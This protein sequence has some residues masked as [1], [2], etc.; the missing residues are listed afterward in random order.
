M[1]DKRSPPHFHQQKGVVLIALLTLIVL[2]FSALSLK[3]LNRAELKR[4]KLDKSH[5]VLAEAKQALIAY[6]SENFAAVN[7]GTNCP[8]PGDL[9]CPDL[10]NDGEAEGT[11]STQQSRL[12]RLPW[13]TLG[14]NDLKD[15]DGESLWYAV[16]NRYKNN[17]RL[18]PL[19][20]NTTGS[21]SLRNTSGQLINDASN[22]NGLV[23]LVIA[24]H[25]SLSRSDG[26]QQSRTQANQLVAS[27]YL[28]IAFGEDN[29]SFTEDSA[30]GFITGEIVQNDQLIV[31]DLILPITSAQI[32]TVMQKRVLSEVMQA[33]LEFYCNGQMQ[34]STRQCLANNDTFLPVPAAIGN[35]TCLTN[36]D[37][38]LNDCVAD[39][40][41]NFGRIPNAMPDPNDPA[42]P[43]AIW[44][45]VNTQSILRG[46]Q[47]NNWF[48]QNAWREL[49]FYAPAPACTD[50]TTNGCEVTEQFLTLTNSL[51]P[52]AAA[53]DLNKQLVLVSAGTRLNAQN[54]TTLTDKSVL[55]NYV[56][57]DNLMPSDFIYNRTL[58]NANQ[59][60][61]ATSIP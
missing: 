39:D 26:Q 2:I 41:Q 24:P 22:N 12:G 48:Q 3:Q 30:D 34:V 16:S 55:S 49:I 45:A 28:E 33:M 1:P 43:V 23:A 8:R 29:A 27:H 56:E 14:L 17:P 60:D 37:L 7:C 58:Q 31:N 9:P 50:T 5:L 4:L 25:A 20:S 57:G 51:T 47:T 53:S 11:C 19:N 35:T 44:E 18:L 42:T 46:A 10:D 15:G 54:R 59:N 61:L 32:Q 21:I 6:A 36:A 38:S 52:L 13:K 40:T